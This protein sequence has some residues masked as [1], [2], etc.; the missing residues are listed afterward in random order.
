MS[1]TQP[2]NQTSEMAREALGVLSTVARR[3]G[4]A[5]TYT[6]ALSDG[7]PEAC[8]LPR[9]AFELLQEILGHLA[10]GTA[11]TVLPVHAE[12]TT[13]GAADLL[14]VSRPHLVKLLE[15]GELPFHRVGTHRRVRLEDLMEY[16]ARVEEEQ[17]QALDELAALS[18]DME[19]GY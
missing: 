19:M 15:E 13:Q 3:Q 4:D 5:D 7:Q 18:Q 16:K 11:V 14:N 8:I 9:A 1:I 6:V 2:S 12:L 10:N 17:R